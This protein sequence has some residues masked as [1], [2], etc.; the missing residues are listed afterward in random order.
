MWGAVAQIATKVGPHVL[1]AA[2]GATASK[3]VDKVVDG[4]GTEEKTHS[5]R[6]APRAHAEVQ[7]F[8]GRH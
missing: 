1:N 4:T 2:L 3:V 8:R 6:V 5:Q 7:K